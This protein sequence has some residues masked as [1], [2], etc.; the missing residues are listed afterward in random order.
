M[1][2]PLSALS[3][4]YDRFISIDQWTTENVSTKK[5]TREKEKK[6]KKKK[7]TKG[8]SLNMTLRSVKALLSLIHI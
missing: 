3:T 1:L 4:T 8:K 5:V 2:M 6:R 7:R